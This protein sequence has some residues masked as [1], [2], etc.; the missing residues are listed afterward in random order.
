MSTAFLL[1]TLL[2]APPA[3]DVP[4]P[5]SAFGFE[6][7]AERELATYEEIAGYFR[8]LDAASDRMNLYEIGKT[9]EGRTMLL[10]VISSEENLRNLD[11]HKAISKRLGLREGRG[12]REARALAKEGKAVV[13]IDFGLHSTER[14]PAPP[15]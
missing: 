5:A 14:A 11:R 10:S 12:S 8:K 4:T 1:L 13:W 3:N 15:A 7:C 2:A 6:P 9:A